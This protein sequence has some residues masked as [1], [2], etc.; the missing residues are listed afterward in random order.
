[1][2]VSTENIGL[3]RVADGTEIVKVGRPGR[4]EFA[5]WRYGEQMV[6]RLRKFV[7]LGTAGI[8]S[9]AWVVLAP[10]TLPILPGI[11]AIPGGL[12]TMLALPQ[13]LAWL[14]RY[15]RNRRI[16]AKPD[17]ESGD[18]LIVRFGH[19]PSAQL[20]TSLAVEDDVG[21]SVRVKHDKGFAEFQGQRALGITGKILAQVNRLG[22]T[23]SAV[24]CAVERLESAGG[25]GALFPQIALEAQQRPFTVFQHP[26]GENP[27]GTIRSLP[28]RDRL[29]LEMATHEE[30]ERRALEGE[31]DALED[32]WREAEEIARI[33]DSLA[34]PD[35]V[36]ED[37][38]KL[39]IKA[40][41]E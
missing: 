18:I 30:S 9:S 40:G 12:V 19:L 6:R 41:V 3:A 38:R 20:I 13:A 15:Y 25:C 28:Y 22:A 10:K 27:P 26:E 32:A 23:A 29:A 2:R 16:I 36:E 34:V 35:A 8:A 31:L 5:A 17:L 4:S 21:W 39:R 33:A 14:S 11:L 24:Q 37:L 7:A 1:M